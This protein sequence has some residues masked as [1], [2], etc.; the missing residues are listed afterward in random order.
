MDYPIIDKYEY[1][2]VWLDEKLSPE[3]HLK[4]Y[5]PSINYLQS[6][7]ANLRQGFFL[8]FRYANYM[9]YMSMTGI[10][11]TIRK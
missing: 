5:K 3:I 11:T 10:T 4:S 9:K 7:P 6:D 1:L 8:I 2:G